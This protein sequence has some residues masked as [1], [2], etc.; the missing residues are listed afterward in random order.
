MNNSKMGPI[1][2]SRN[3]TLRGL[4]I[5]D[6][7]SEVYNSPL[8]SYEEDR[9]PDLSVNLYSPPPPYVSEVSEVKYNKSIHHLNVSE[10]MTGFDYDQ[11]MYPDQIIYPDQKMF[12][13][14]LI[15]SAAFG[16]FGNVLSFLVLSRS[17]FIK[18]NVSI[19]LRILA[20]VDT[21]VLWISWD[22]LYLGRMNY[23]LLHIRNWLH[24]SLALI[25]SW[26]LVAMSFE[27]AIGIQYPHKARIWLTRKRAIIVS[28][29][30]SIFYSIFPILPYFGWDGH[31]FGPAIILYTMYSILP[32]LLIILC[33]AAIIHALV[34]A[35][36][37]HSKLSAKT[38]SIH[39]SD[40]NITLMLIT[41][42]IVFI[43][44]TMPISALVM[45][46]YTPLDVG[47]FETL[48]YIAPILR[49]ISQLNHAINFLLYS[50]SGSMFRSELIQMFKCQASQAK[51][52][53]LP[54]H[55]MN[56]E[57]NALG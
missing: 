16:T 3:L 5:G 35:S 33:N 31:V 26:L 9:R 25:S 38:K 39:R 20:V 22:I 2:S 17:T 56:Q 23:W 4:V 21:I 46:F 11:T 52:S 29:V 51:P 44:L 37:V 43:V 57:N 55:Q 42:G 53:D 14:I 34:K 54:L 27:R 47:Q 10:N 36:K 6:D 32:G 7:E 41:N 24:C 18:K 12:M 13:I 8:P 1:L 15:I 50:M 30:I 28:L 48:S 40:M 19:Y 49:I 45:T